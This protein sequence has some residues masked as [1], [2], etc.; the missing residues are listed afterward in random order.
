[1]QFFACSMKSFSAINKRSIRERFDTKL[2]LHKHESLINIAQ[3]NEWNCFICD[4]VVVPNKI[5]CLKM[6]VHLNE[7]KSVV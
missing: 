2:K 7:N 3:S 6:Y 1:M 5:I 4:A